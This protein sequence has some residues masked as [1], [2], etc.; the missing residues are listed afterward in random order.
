ML[1]D[2]TRLGAD[3]ALVVDD[4]TKPIPRIPVTLPDGATVTPTALLCPQ[5]LT[6]DQWQSLGR[7]L[8]QLGNS[9]QW[10]IGD[11]WHYGEHRYGERKTKAKGEDVFDY[12]FGTLMNFGWVAGQIKASRRNEVL[13]FSHHVAVADQEPKQQEY[14]L[15][16][17]E[18]N[19]WSVAKLRGKISDHKF[20][21]N[22]LNNGPDH[23]YARLGHRLENAAKISRASLW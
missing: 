2:N 3:L 18:K 22:K 20:V 19:K 15:S 7:A 21:T 14:W 6:L 16:V 13:S 17:A 1:E 10:W 11:W 8:A 4:D 9:V 12:A 5:Q 23:H